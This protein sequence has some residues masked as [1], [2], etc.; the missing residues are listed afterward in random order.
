MDDEQTEGVPRKWNPRFVAY[1]T[2]HGLQPEGMLKFD[3]AVWPGGR[4]VGFILWMSKAFT[5]WTTELGVR[6]GN[7]FTARDNALIAH[8]HAAFD[9][10]LNAYALKEAAC[11]SAPS[12]PQSST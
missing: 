6:G 3:A 10:W 4:C 8:G 11:L 12:N 7:G 2:A 5:A 9:T 1:C